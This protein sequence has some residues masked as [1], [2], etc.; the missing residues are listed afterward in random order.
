MAPRSLSGH[1]HRV[2]CLA[3]SRDGKR[4]YTGGDDR[5]IKV[6]NLETG[7]EVDALRGHASGVDDLALSAD[8]KRLVSAGGD[9]KVWD[10]FFFQ[11][12]DGIRDGTVTGVQT[13]ALPI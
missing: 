12:E 4:L 1:V 2:N 5:T 11:A 3:L 7:K 9:I 6:W 13:C 10:L 8:G